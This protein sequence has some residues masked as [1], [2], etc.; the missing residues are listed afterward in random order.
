MDALEKLLKSKDLSDRAIQLALR[1]IDSRLLALALMNLD[2]KL[3]EVAYRN[4]SK[5]ATNLI[6]QIIYTSKDIAGDTV[7]KDK[8]TSIQNAQA[9]FYDLLCNAKKQNLKDSK[10]KGLPEINLKN[11]T[12]IINTFVRLTEHTKK[13]GIFSLNGIEEKTDHPLMKKGLE[14]TLDGYEPLYQK[15][16][17]EKYKENYLKAVERQLDMIMEGIDMLACGCGPDSIEERLN[18]YA[19]GLPE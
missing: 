15:S 3:K 10:A 16:L 4:M 13:Y 6:K 5:R 11:E 1:E 2:E 14:L 8:N 18:P 12:E 19:F 7:D 17:L 9:L